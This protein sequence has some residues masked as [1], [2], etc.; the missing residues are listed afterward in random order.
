ML[1]FQKRSEKLRYIHRVTSGSNM[2]RSKV[3]VLEDFGAM[4]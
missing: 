1:M 4:Y 2:Y 3:M